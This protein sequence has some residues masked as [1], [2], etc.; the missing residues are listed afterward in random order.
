MVK[1]RK[2]TRKVARKAVKEMMA[3]KDLKAEIDTRKKW[4]KSAVKDFKMSI[5]AVMKRFLTD[6]K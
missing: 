1:K 5:N 2:L 6:V 3:A 4:L